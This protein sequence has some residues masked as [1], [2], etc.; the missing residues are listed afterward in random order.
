MPWLWSFMW[1]SISF[2]MQI[3][4]VSR[5]KNR[6]FFPCGAFLSR[7][8]HDYLSSDL[9]SRK[10]L[11]PKYFLV[12]CLVYYS[13]SNGHWRSVQVFILIFFKES[14]KNYVK[15]IFWILIYCNPLIRTWYAKK[16]RR[17]LNWSVNNNESVINGVKSTQHF[18][19]QKSVH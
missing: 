2:K 3:L 19:L 18:Q 12:T 16:M 17:S 9:I 4:R 6:R 7:V 11:C 1:S 5:S 13:S 14:L 8:V 15:Q 10:L